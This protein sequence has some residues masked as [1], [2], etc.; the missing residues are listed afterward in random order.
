TNACQAMVEKNKDTVAEAANSRPDRLK[1]ESRVVRGRYQ[2]RVFDTGPGIHPDE[3]EKVF[4]PLYST[5]GFGVGLGLAI[6]KQIME[7]HHGGVEIESQPGKGT[8]VTLWLPTS[9]QQDSP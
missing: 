5:K 1:V 2:V 9:H 8:V 4:Q 6:V 7:L 3:L